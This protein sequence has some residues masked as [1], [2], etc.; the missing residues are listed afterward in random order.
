MAENERQLAEMLDGTC[1]KFLH[2]EL[3]RRAEGL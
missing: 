1:A 3:Q 2:E